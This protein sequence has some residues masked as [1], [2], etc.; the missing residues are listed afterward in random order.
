[1]KTVCRKQILLSFVTILIGLLPVCAAAAETES[2]KCAHDGKLN[3]A[4]AKAALQ[5]AQEAYSAL[6]NMKA[7]FRQESYLAAL[8][9]SEASSGKLYFQKPGKMRWDYELPEEQVFLIV[10]QTL[11]YYQAYDRQLVIDKFSKFLISDLPVAFI[12]GIGDL[13]K[14]FDLEYACRNSDGGTLFGLKP[15]QNKITTGG[16]DQG[17]NKFELLVD[18]KSSL[19]SAARIYDL[20]GNINTFIFED[21]QSESTVPEERFLPDFPDGVDIDD[22]RTEAN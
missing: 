3:P 9:T 18:S 19:P 21:M 2:L 15:K 14:S 11:W 5:K 4:Q 13:G 10:D 16:S 1:M 22:R 17:L 7:G 8:E 20:A 6:L 12:L